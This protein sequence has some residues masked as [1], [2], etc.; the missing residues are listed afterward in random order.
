MKNSYWFSLVSVLFVLAFAASVSAQQPASQQPR[1][2]PLWIAVVDMPSVIKAHPV[3]VDEIP[4]IQQAFQKD[5]LEAQKYEQSCQKQVEQIKQQFKYG[6]P[7]FEEA[8]KPIKEGLRQAQVQ[9]QDKQSEVM[10]EANKL[11]YKVYS[12]IQQ[13]VKQVAEQKGIVIV[14]TKIKLDRQGVAEEVVAVQE[15]DAN[16]ML[17]WN[18]PGID[19]TEDVKKALVQIA[20]TPKNS[21]GGAL[22]NITGQLQANAPA[23]APQA[24]APQNALAPQQRPLASAQAPNAR[25][26]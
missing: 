4:L 14:H 12:D 19:I 13:A 10:T 20:G 9:L 18:H 11:Q 25:P 2:Q 17:V 1:Q 26:Q 3:T 22:G 16:S 23:A 21:A 5:V 15:A 7:Q 24:A 8:V 6:S